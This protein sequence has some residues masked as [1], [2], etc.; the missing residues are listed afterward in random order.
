MKKLTDI[1]YERNDIELK[2]G[3]F[4]VKGDC[5]DIFPSWDETAIR[6]E[7]FGDEVDRRDNECYEL[8]YIIDHVPIG[9][10]L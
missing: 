6:I 10:F 7:L 3:R 9:Q 2:R 8:F 5:L 1:Y 4:R